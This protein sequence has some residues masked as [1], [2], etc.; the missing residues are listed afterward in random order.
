MLTNSIILVISGRGTFRPLGIDFRPFANSVCDTK[1]HKRYIKIA[2]YYHWFFFTNEGNH[3]TM[4]MS[5]LLILH[6]QN[7]ALVGLWLIHLLYDLEYPS[8]GSFKLILVSN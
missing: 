1:Y 6:H 4:L 5:L 3:C 8:L 2:W 7:L